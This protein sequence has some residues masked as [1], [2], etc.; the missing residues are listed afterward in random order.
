MKRKVVDQ[1]RKEQ[2]EMS[3]QK[4]RKLEMSNL[5]KLTVYPYYKI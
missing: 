5:D 1:R 2:I 3:R 4:A